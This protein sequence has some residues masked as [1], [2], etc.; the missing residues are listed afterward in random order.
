M[1]SALPKRRPR[2]A[3]TPRR[4]KTLGVANAHAGV[5]RDPKG[6]R[7]NCAS[8]FPCQSCSARKLTNARLGLL[9][10]ATDHLSRHES[11]RLLGSHQT[12]RA[13]HRPP[14]HK[15]SGLVV[16]MAADEQVPPYTI[17]NTAVL[18]PIPN[19]SVTIT[20][21]K[22]HGDRRKTRMACRTSST[23]SRIDYPA[24]LESSFLA[25]LGYPAPG[26]DSDRGDVL[27]A[28]EAA[29]GR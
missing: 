3:D 18:A 19:A 22:N 29:A 1:S 27:V 26:P 23:S 16:G 13:L 15:R 12:G 2:D 8:K 24:A 28:G 17:E 25:I 9:A 11:T 6:V 14:E 7:S 10:P 4:S 21:T 20:P 5:R